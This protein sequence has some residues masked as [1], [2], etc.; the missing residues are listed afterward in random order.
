MIA[1]Y[2]TSTEEWSWARGIVIIDGISHDHSIMHMHAY[3]FTV[4]LLRFVAY[5]VPVSSSI[6]AISS[7]VLPESKYCKPS[8]QFW[9]KITRFDTWKNVNNTIP[10]RLVWSVCVTSCKGRYNKNFDHS[11]VLKGDLSSD[12]PKLPP[13]TIK[14]PCR[15]FTVRSTGHYNRPKERKQNSKGLVNSVK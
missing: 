6:Q 9:S 7:S 13:V 14:K 1:H 10:Q 3:L 11:G 8:V 15:P 4:R 2:T 5:M 12:H